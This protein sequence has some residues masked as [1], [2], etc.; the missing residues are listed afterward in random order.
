VILK[1][2]AARADV[3]AS[4]YKGQKDRQ[5]AEAVANTVA[6]ALV[7]YYQESFTSSPKA[8]SAM[9]KALHAPSYTSITKGPANTKA[10][11]S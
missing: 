7:A 10:G 11:T 4:G 2:F 6:R 1:D 8:T 9:P 3:F 5:I